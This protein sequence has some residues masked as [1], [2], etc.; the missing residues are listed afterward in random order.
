MLCDPAGRTLK[1]FEPELDRLQ[2]QVLGLLGVPAAAYTLPGQ[3]R[4]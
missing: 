2:L 1:V 4:Q 3:I